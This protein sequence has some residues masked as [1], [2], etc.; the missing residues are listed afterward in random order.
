MMDREGLGKRLRYYRLERGMTQE[1]LA[2]AA[3]ISA[4]HLGHIERGTRV[5]S[6]QVLLTLCNVLHTTPNDLLGIAPVSQGQDENERMAA[7]AHELLMYIER[8][9]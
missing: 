7:M 2:E 9:I 3:Q 1:Q 8:L 6:L 4:S 5:V